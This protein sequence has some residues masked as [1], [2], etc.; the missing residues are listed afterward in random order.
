MSVRIR[1]ART[2]A[3]LDELFRL[4]HR[5]F[6]AEKGWFPSQPDG[7]IADRFDAYPTTTNIIAV[8]DGRVVGG[9]RFVEAGPLGMPTDRYFDFSPFLPP[10]AKV[11]SAG[12]LAVGPG[13]RSAP[14]L[15]SAMISM[16][17]YWGL[18]RRLTH[19]VAALNPGAARIFLATGGRAA[20]P[21]FLHEPT[22][23]PVVPAVFDLARL[24]ERF[25]AF[26]RRQHVAHP[27]ESFERQLHPAGERIIS[28]G[29]EANAAF[30]IVHGEV[31]VAERLN[32]YSPRE[33]RLGR[34]GAFGELAL[35]TSR[36][37]PAGV[38][39]LTDVELMVL[40]R[41]AFAALPGNPG[42]RPPSVSPPG[43]GEARRR[44]SEPG[45]GT[46]MRPEIGPVPAADWPARRGR[47]RVLIE[48]PDPAWHRL[49]EEV[50]GADYELASC[51]GPEAR[52]GGCPLVAHRGCPLAEGA[53]VIL[54]SFNLDQVAN[55]EV[56]CAL[57]SCCPGVPV[58]ALTSPGEAH[59]HGGCLEGHRAEILPTSTS[60]LARLVARLPLPTGG[61]PFSP[62]GLQ[63]TG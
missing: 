20:A 47:P 55:R 33:V 26:A 44:R 58:V 39:A 61:Q 52:P 7:R 9:I 43:A 11:F 12:M 36:R 31:E 1:L 37:H 4:R 42:T 40:E 57:Q 62:S 34:G 5:V 21:E 30:V 50:L 23:L 17:Y 24:D 18:T 2:E 41:D 16:G 28:P 49:V 10:D 45:S 46:R 27:F 25:L 6:V 35:L 60:D 32:G 8:V 51:G 38:V 13:G 14:R 56:L 22:G 63:P 48:E 54:N 3:E 53:D 59:R 19:F 15:V 29:E